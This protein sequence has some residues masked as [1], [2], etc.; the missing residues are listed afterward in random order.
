MLSCFKIQIIGFAIATDWM[1]GIFFYPE[2]RV[3]PTCGI[4][5]VLD[6]MPPVLAAVPLHVPDKTSEVFALR[7]HC[8]RTLLAASLWTAVKLC[9]IHEQWEALGNLLANHQG[10]ERFS[11]GTVPESCGSN[12][13]VQEMQDDTIQQVCI[14]VILS[15]ILICHG[16]QIPSGSFL[17]GVCV[18]SSYI[19]GL[20]PIFSNKPKTCF[21]G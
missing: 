10:G 15:V 1:N 4:W 7:L 5:Q 20:S 11:N 13:L 18:F 6:E 12:R 16:R 9:S 14:D 2:G 19:C 17:S 8:I 21:T 3:L